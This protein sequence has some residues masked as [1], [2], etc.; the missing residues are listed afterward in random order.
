MKSNRLISDDTHQCT[1]NSSRGREEVFRNNNVPEYVYVINNKEIA[2]LKSQLAS[3][4]ETTNNYSKLQSNYRTVSNN[5]TSLNESI[6]HYR[7]K[8]LKLTQK[9]NNEIDQFNH[10]NNTLKAKIKDQHT[11]KRIIDEDAKDMRF[12]YDITVNDKGVYE[13]KLKEKEND[14]NRLNDD[15]SSL[16]IILKNS[17]QSKHDD[18]TALKRN[19]QMIEDKNNDSDFKERLIGEMNKMNNDFEKQNNELIKKNGDMNDTIIKKE[20]EIQKTKEE[21]IDYD[22]KTNDVSRLIKSKGSNI[23]QITHDLN[24]RMMEL[25]KIEEYNTSL[26]RDINMKENEMLIKTNLIQTSQNHINQLKENTELLN[27]ELLIANNDLQIKKERGDSLIKRNQVYSSE[28]ENVK[29]NDSEISKQ[30]S[31]IKAI[32]EILSKI[33]S[34]MYKKQKQLENSIEINRNFLL[35]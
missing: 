24:E 15:I 1:H 33:K 20:N 17:E 9:S 16:R 29:L 23:E 28:L 12:H 5:I 35:S 19:R 34:S 13:K 8:L 30:L 10:M 31:D 3:L 18:K 26:E 27:N 11:E 14:I 22:K 7:I 32:E 4:E 6:V 2:N 21:I 25:N